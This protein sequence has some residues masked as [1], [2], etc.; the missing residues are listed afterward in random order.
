MTLVKPPSR[1]LC[2]MFTYDAAAVTTSTQTCPLF[3]RSLG[4]NALGGLSVLLLHCKHVCIRT[5]RLV[6]KRLKNTA[7]L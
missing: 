4:K 3:V 7:S 2:V 6:L 5:D 1:Y